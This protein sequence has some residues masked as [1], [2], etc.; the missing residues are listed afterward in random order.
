MP[1]T[2][3]IIRSFL[4]FVSDVLVW[5]GCVWY[6]GMT[7]LCLV[8]WYDMVVFPCFLFT[9]CMSTA[10]STLAVDKGDWSSVSDRVTIEES[11]Q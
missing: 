8:C 5:Y 4:N 7:W 9:V 11:V 2:E 3:R 10:H 1:I 6:A